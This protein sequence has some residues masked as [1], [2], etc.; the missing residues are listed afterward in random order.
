[1]RLRTRH[2]VSFLPLFTLPFACSSEPA[3]EYGTSGPTDSTTTESTS[4]GDMTVTTG[5]NTTTSTGTVG[6]TGSGTVGTTGV[7]DAA[8][9]TGTDG[10]TGFT[11]S[12][13]TTDGGQTVTSS[14]SS[15]GATTDGTT[16]SSAGGA[17][18]TGDVSSTTGGDAG[19]TNPSPGCG[20]SGRPSG[21]KVYVAGESWLLFPESYDGNTP[22]PVIFGFH[23]CGSGNR[24]DASRT[25][26]SDLTN[27]NA[28][29]S[30]Y[31]NA[32]PLSSDAGGCWTYNTDITRVK[33]LYDELLNNYCV[34][35]DH[36]F[37]TGH[38]SGSQFIV[39]TLLGSH[40]ADAQYLNFRGVAPVAASNYGP[41]ATP[42]P[43]M[44][45]QNTN[46]SERG[47][48]GKDEVDQFVAGNS[49]SSTSMPYT[50]AGAGCQSSGVT[51]DPN[52]IQYD[53]CDVPTI[54]CSHN[55]PQY[56]GTGH[57]V[58]CFFAQATDEF[59]KS[60]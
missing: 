26:F 5:A 12:V 60:L 37:A 20:K 38:S 48:S 55:D 24:G 11:S 7:S 18:T 32:I 44:Y 52:C 57:G 51:V 41:H 6:T 58:P 16:G 25:E 22:F 49:C 1:M 28:L 17:S 33:A 19:G 9:S 59:F 4:A 40:T 29:G 45:I 30:D 47:G 34:D 21:G 31:V 15:G 35:I 42:M 46:D 56:S 3:Q 27:G 14:S 23:G 53:G 50:A 36:V 39:Q 8:V 43:V 54:W 10:T 2:I 13:G